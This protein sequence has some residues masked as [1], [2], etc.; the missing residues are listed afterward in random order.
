MPLWYI[1]NPKQVTANAVNDDYGQKFL[2]DGDAGSGPFKIKRWDGQAVM[3]LDAVEDYWKGWPMDAAD[4]PAGIIYR[5]I[6]EPAPRKAAL[7]RG[8]IDM[9]TEMTPDDYDEMA[10]MPGIVVNVDHRHDAIHHPD[11][12][13]EGRRPPTS[14]SARRWPYAFDYDALLQIENNAA[15]L[16]DSPFP[17]AMTGHVAIAGIPRRNLDLAKQYLAKTKTPQGGIE[18]DVSLRR[19]PGGGT[20]DRPGGAGIAAAAEHQGERGGAAL[21][22]PGGARCQGG[23]GGRHG[24]GLCHAG[25]HRSRRRSP[26]ST[27]PPPRDSS[28]ACTICTTPSWTP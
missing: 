11:E 25:Q 27:P 15:K 10:K 23:N 4:R 20:P 17:N 18:I 28:G 21:A 7:Q 14:I 2:T 16:M 3:A 6:R 26:R 22:H 13:A 1:V 12:H 24:R 5:V 8:E 9:V 19:R